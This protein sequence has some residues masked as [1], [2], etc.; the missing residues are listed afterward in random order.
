MNTGILVKAG[1]LTMVVC[2]LIGAYLKITHAP[3]GETL[4]MVALLASLIFIVSAIYEVN[5]SKRIHR[6]EKVMWTLGFLFTSGIAGIVYML[7]AR[8]RIVQ[9]LT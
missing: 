4:L 7:S 3:G 1:L 9:R 2:S 8:K 5:V 6:S